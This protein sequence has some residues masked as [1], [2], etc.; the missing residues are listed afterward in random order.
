MKK[1]I[2]HEQVDF[3]PGMQGWYNIHKPI[4]IKQHINRTKDKNTVISIDTEEGIQQNS[5][6]FHDKSSKETRNRRDVPPHNKGYVT[7]P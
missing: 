2:H 6:S 4:N 7:S 3:T 1:I 5:T